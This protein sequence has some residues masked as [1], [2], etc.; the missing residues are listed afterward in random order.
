MIGREMILTY[1]SN[2]FA[3]FTMSERKVLNKYFPPDF[4][5]DLIPKGRVGSFGG[6]KVR[7]MMPMSVR[8]DM[9]KQYIYKGKKFNAKK[10]TVRNEEYLGIEIFRFYVRCPTCSSEITFKTD[11]QNA[12]YICEHGATRNFESWR[13]EKIANDE[14]SYRKQFEEMMDPMKALENKTYD[15]KREI[16]ILEKLDEIQTRNALHERA[17]AD[18]VFA[19]IQE[20]RNSALQQQRDL[21]KK[22]EESD[23]VLARSVFRD[24]EGVAVKRLLDHELEADKRPSVFHSKSTNSQKEQN[25]F[26]KPKQPPVALIKKKTTDRKP[27]QAPTTSLAGIANYGS[28]SDESDV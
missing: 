28:D 25:V 23:D 21:K 17:D 6:Y 26:K 4:D 12:D 27:G 3:Q 13:E 18:D 1:R 15:S 19:K 9:C 5:P 24:S 10:E 11:P 14:I 2:Q 16:D 7:L 22:E 8:C 20:S